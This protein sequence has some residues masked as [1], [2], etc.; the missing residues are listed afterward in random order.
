MHE[1]RIFRSISFFR[2][3]PREFLGC[4]AINVSWELNNF[5]PKITG[6]PP[7]V[8]LMSR[9]EELVIKINGLRGDLKYYFGGMLDNRG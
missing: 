2:N 9:M 7:R 5:T 3:I 4:A 8:L 6:V 1:E